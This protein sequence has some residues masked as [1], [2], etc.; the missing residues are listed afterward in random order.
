MRSPQPPVNVNA[1]SQLQFPDWKDVKRDQGAKYNTK[2]TMAE[3]VKSK[4]K[5]KKEMKANVN[6]TPKRWGYV[7]DTSSN[8]R[9]SKS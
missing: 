1:R 6:K 8:K 2:T 5:N 7:S 4:N 9:Y 3:R